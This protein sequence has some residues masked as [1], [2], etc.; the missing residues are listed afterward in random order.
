MFFQLADR[1][2]LK[3]MFFFSFIFL[4][5]ELPAQ[6]VLVIDSRLMILAHPLTQKFDPETHRFKGTSSEPVTGGASGV[7]ELKE[8]MGEIRIKLSGLVADYSKKFEKANSSDKL[9]LEK[10]FFAEKSFFENRLK[11]L[12]ERSSEAIGVPGSPGMTP[13]SSI[14]PQV[15]KISQDIKTVLQELSRKNSMIP[16]LDISSLI[17]LLPE[18]LPAP[19][20][21]LLSQN[22][23]FLLWSRKSPQ[24]ETVLPWIQEAGNY[25]TKREFNRFSPVPFGGKDLRKEAAKLIS[26]QGTVQ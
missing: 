7:A 5:S 15:L 10:K 12:D 2:F 21:D 23:H 17:P 1:L 22:L 13:Y 14:I 24:K 20:Q 19:K 11:M 9:L 18:D 25:W 26:Q 4:A 8:E 16:V 6:S 3:M